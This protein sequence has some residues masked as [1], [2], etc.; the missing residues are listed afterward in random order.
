MTTPIALQLYTLR[1]EL[2]RDFDSMI[3]KIAD[4][5][6]TGVETASFAGTNVKSAAATFKELGLTVCGAHLPLPVGERQTEVLETMEALDCRRL[7]CAWLPPENFQTAAGIHQVCDRLNEAS[8]VARA[9][10]LTLGYHNH[11]FEF[12]PVGDRLAHEIL[13]DC[14]S[15][16]VFFELDTYWVQTAGADPAAVLRELGPRVSLVHIK[17]GPA[18]RGQPMQALGEGVIDIPSLVE[19]SAG[20]AEW[21]IVELDE[22]ATDMFEAVQR[23][24]NYLAKIGTGRD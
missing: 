14:L 22:C 21:L 18:V 17:D 15:P 1:D 6:Y 7:I 10:G 24:Y 4:I 11:D 3:R 13:R 23:S 12:K 9:H 20:S 8:A 16:E 5:G 2:A 19:A